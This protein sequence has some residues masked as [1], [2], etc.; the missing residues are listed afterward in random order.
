MART[1]Y[2]NRL[3]TISGMIRL[4]VSVSHLVTCKF[5]PSFICHF[6]IRDS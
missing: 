6:L 4:D 2:V 3:A 1:K 5:F